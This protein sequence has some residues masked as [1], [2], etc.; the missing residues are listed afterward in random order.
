MLEYALCMHGNFLLRTFATLAQLTGN[1]G[2]E[3]HAEVLIAVAQR[4]L[5]KRPRVAA[6]LVRALNRVAG[7]GKRRNALM[8]AGWGGFHE[9]KGLAPPYRSKDGKVFYGGLTH[10]GTRVRSATIT[11]PEIEALAKEIGDVRIEI[12]RVLASLPGPIGIAGGR[13]PPP[14]AIPARVTWKQTLAVHRMIARELKQRSPK[15]P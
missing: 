3:R 13:L 5:H 4:I 10:R 6:R 2:G 11:S 8:H 15:K 9:V 14:I 1:A 7:L 12:N